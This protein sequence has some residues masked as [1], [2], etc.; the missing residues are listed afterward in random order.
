V[1]RVN[2]RGPFVAGRCL[3][4][5]TGAFS[6]IASMG[7]GVATVRYSVLSMG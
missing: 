1:V 6:R 5:T 3:D 4:L 2:D 7:A